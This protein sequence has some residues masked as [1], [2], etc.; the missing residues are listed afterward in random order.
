MK[1]WLKRIIA[2]AGL[3]GMGAWLAARA[4]R[5]RRLNRDLNRE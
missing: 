1:R 5:R 3:L 4:A 2:L